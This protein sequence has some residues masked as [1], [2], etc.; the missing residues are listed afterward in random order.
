MVL[1]TIYQIGIERIYQYQIDIERIS[2]SYGHQL[3]RSLYGQ[4]VILFQEQFVQLLSKPNK[5][6]HANMSSIA[7]NS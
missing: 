7:L 5:M 6:L 3:Y 4:S 1:L 2:V